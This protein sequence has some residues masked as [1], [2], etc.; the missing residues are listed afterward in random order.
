MTA[1]PRSVAA[2]AHVP[3]LLGATG[4]VDPRPMHA[5]WEL[6]PAL[7]T[8]LLVCAVALFVWA[9]RAR[10]RA[11]PRTRTSSSSCCLRKQAPQVCVMRVLAAHMR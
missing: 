6:Y 11:T 8:V 3:T 9:R 2:R 4:C 5:R 7:A 10:R 1:A